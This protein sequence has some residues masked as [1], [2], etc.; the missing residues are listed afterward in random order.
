MFALHVSLTGSYREPRSLV[1]PAWSV[2]G[3][4]KATH[5]LA[6]SGKTVPG[7]DGIRTL[8][9]PRFPNHLASECTC[10]QTAKVPDGTASAGF[11]LCLL[12]SC[13]QE[14]VSVAAIRCG[15]QSMLI[16]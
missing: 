5:R 12:L 8:L 13:S 9:G 3:W 14:S 15:L 1:S 2:P 11:R 10:N 7:V 16:A 4:S 6:N